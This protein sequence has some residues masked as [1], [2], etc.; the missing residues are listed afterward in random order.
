MVLLVLAVLSVKVI[1]TKAVCASLIS[2]VVATA[3]TA[4]LV[5][6]AVVGLLVGST[7][8]LG[9]CR[10]TDRPPRIPP[11]DRLPPT[12]HLAPAVAVVIVVMG[13]G[14]PFPPCFL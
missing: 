7:S 8:V 11:T 9:R 1:I 4:A 6:S 5:L 13:V 3:C 10:P 14:S 12:T 2:V